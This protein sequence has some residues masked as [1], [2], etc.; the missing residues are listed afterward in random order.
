MNSAH[1]DI[2]NDLLPA[3]Q[4]VVPA[5]NDFILGGD[6]RIECAGGARVVSMAEDFAAFLSESAGARPALRE[7]A[8]GGDLFIRIVSGAGAGS[9]PRAA[10]PAGNEAYILE[11]GPGE[12]LLAARTQAG[13]RWGLMTLRQMVFRH[14]AGARIRGAR[15]TD[16]PR[17]AWRGFQFDSGRSP[18]SVPKMKRIIRICSAFKLNF[19]IFREG[20]DELN[21]VRYKSNPLGSENPCALSLEDLAGLAAYARERGIVMVPEVES[22]GHSGAKGLH[23]PDLV[24]GGFEHKYKGVGVH[25][26]KAHLAPRDPRSLRLLGSMYR[27]L[28][29]A[30]RPPM[31]HLGLDEVRLPPEIQAGHFKAVLGEFF[32]AS[33]NMDALVWSDCPPTPPEERT[34][35]VRCLWEYGDGLPIGLDNVNLQ[36]QGIGALAAPGCRERV[37]MAGGSGSGH[38]PYSKSSLEGACRNLAAWAEFGAGRDNFAGLFAVQWSGNM[39]DEWLAD[40]LCAADFGWRPPSVP[41]VFEEQMRRVKTRLAVLP[42]AARPAASEIDRPA[43]DGIWLEGREWG[44]EILPAR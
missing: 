6:L 21:A 40:F 37:F 9:G 38:T 43:W 14:G 36:R 16:F 2:L 41:P 27:E 33:G 25:V 32:A 24:G 13:L 26:R 17:Y 12:V 23:Y 11:S 4:Q 31:I 5:G 18:N 39:T 10:V 22:L 8:G 44:A 20:D 19:F 29:E 28:A 34:R 15:I 1:D 35:V 42:D 30:V 3:P 7:T